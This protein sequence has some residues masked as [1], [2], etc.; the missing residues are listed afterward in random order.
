MMPHDSHK[1]CN[2]PASLLR[3]QTPFTPISLPRLSSHYMADLIPDDPVTAVLYNAD[4][5]G[6]I[7]RDL[8]DIEQAPGSPCE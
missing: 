8:W 2:F 6:S 1:A 4:L 7:C 3:P 5:L